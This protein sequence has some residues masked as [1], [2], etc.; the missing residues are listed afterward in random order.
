MNPGETLEGSSFWSKIHGNLRT[1]IYFG[2]ND[3]S[4]MFNFFLVHPTS[5]VFLDG[6]TSLIFKGDFGKLSYKTYDCKTTP[7]PEIGVYY[8]DIRYKYELDDLIKILNSKEVALR[9]YSN[10]GYIDF[11]LN[12]E[13]FD[14][15]K[16]FYKKYLKKK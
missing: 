9:L 16:C 10:E 11:S 5:F 4:Y 15:Y 13:I 14:C 6:E 12:E 1:T 8:Y 2:K 7:A 3:T